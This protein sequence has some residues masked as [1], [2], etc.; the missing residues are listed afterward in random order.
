[1]VLVNGHEER[2]PEGAYCISWYEGKRLTRESVGKD[3]AD[4]N[5]RRLR[6]E[7]ELSAKS[8]GLH[9][10][11]DQDQKNGHGVLIADAIHEFLEEKSLQ[12]KKKTHM[13][14]DT[15]L[16]YFQQSCTKRFLTDISRKD[17]LAFSVYCRDEME[18]SPR[19]FLT[20]LHASWRFL[21]HMALRF[22]SKGTLQDSSSKNPKCT[23][24]KNWKHSS[25][26]A[27]AKSGSGLSSF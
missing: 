14:Y 6:K 7:S 21:R 16:R 11:D 22:I 10:T 26:R 2:H 17:L 13:D 1:M 20:S 24:R 18:L 15:V 12:R 27:G 4:A 5:A 8:N 23:K 9:V 19:P 25:Q 3:A